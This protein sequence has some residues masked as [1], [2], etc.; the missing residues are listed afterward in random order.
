MIYFLKIFCVNMKEKYQICHLNA[1]KINKY[2]VIYNY[3]FFK[4]N[5]FKFINISKLY[6]LNKIELNFKIKF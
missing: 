1:P 5:T 3:Y 2:L 6:F 4:N